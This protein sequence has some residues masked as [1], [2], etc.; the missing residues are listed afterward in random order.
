MTPDYILN[1]NELDFEYEVIAYS[2]NTPVVVDFW[3]T[4]CRPCKTLGPILEKLA[5]EGQG[6]F[7]LAKVNVD[8]NPNLAIRFSIRSIPTVKAFI[9]GQVVDEFMGAQPEPRI[10]EFIGKLVPPSPLKLAQEKAQ[11]LLSLHK[12]TE[13][14]KIFR[15][16]LEQSPDDPALILGLIKSLLAQGQNKEANYL[17]NSFPPSP[18]YAMA[19]KLRP[20]SKALVEFEYNQLSTDTDL[21]AMFR[22]SV[23]LAKLGNFP[24]ALD[25][26]LEILRVNKKYR[27]DTAR[28]VFLSILE[29]LGDEDPLTRQYRSELASVLF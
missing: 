9:D 7:R 10:R 17:L 11:S 1:V 25:G 26:L 22:N 6:H 13:A 4:W 19:E 24:A 5:I 21:D 18:Q 3:A 2:K 15:E 29:I 20:L 12:W 14:E 23:R 8:E 27:N 16:L 28:L